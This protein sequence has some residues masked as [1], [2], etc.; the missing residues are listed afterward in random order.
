MLGQS[1]TKLN[2]EL[3]AGHIVFDKL[4]EAAIGYS[5]EI[6]FAIGQIDEENLIITR[7]K[8]GTKNERL[9]QFWRQMAES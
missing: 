1:R 6:T 9:L 4:T 2:K 3:T 8:D 7:K 5:Y